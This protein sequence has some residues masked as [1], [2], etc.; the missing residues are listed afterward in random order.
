MPA[1]TD[2]LILQG[3]MVEKRYFME[4]RVI[5]GARTALVHYDVLGNTIE[6]LA[7]VESGIPK[8]P[9]AGL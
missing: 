5:F 3:S 9:W 7:I 8:H 6:K 1:K 4:L 2:E